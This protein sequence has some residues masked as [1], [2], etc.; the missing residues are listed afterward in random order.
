MHRLKMLADAAKVLPIISLVGYFILLFC[1]LSLQGFELHIY[2]TNTYFLESQYFKSILGL[3]GAVACVVA[4]TYQIKNPSKAEEDNS[5]IMTLMLGVT[6]GFVAVFF[7]G[8][9]SYLPT[10]RLEVVRAYNNPVIM[11]TSLKMLKVQ[12]PISYARG[13]VYETDEEIEAHYDD[14][15]KDRY[16]RLQSRTLKNG[17]LVSKLQAEL[18]LVGDQKPY[19]DLRNINLKEVW[20][21]FSF[22]AYTYLLIFAWEFVFAKPASKEKPIR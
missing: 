14:R 7:V 11:Q 10:T 22:F 19:F 1:S 8:L 12:E 20:G 5:L 21:Y 4:I 15:I 17:S 18:F 9:L 3:I 2:N 6:V 16:V 13:R